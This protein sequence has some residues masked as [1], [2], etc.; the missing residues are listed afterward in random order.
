MIFQHTR[1]I[2]NNNRVLNTKISPLKLCLVLPEK[3]KKLLRGIN[4]GHFTSHCG[5]PFWHLD[6]KKL[7]YNILKKNKPHNTMTHEM[8]TLSVRKYNNS[9]VGKKI[10]WNRPRG[11]NWKPQ[12]FFWCVNTNKQQHQQPLYFYRG[13]LSIEVDQESILYR[14]FHPIL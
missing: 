13:R 6:R 1:A 8:W 14:K 10:E 11:Q 2:K 7:T 5:K 9:D 4:I 3:Y 12:Q